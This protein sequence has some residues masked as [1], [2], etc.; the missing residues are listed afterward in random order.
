M[1]TSI[2]VSLIISIIGLCVVFGVLVWQT[3]DDRPT[4]ASQQTPDIGRSFDLVSDDGAPITQE[5]LRGR[6]TLLYFGFTYCPDVCP[7]SLQVMTQA[8]EEIEA[9]E[10]SSPQVTPVFV[11]VDP[12]RDTPEALK[13]YVSHFHPRLQGWTGSEEQI[14]AAM[15]SFKVY[16]ARVDDPTVPDGYTIDHSS[17]FYLMDPNGNFLAHFDHAVTPEKLA[18]TLTQLT[19][20]TKVMR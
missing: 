2:R 17:I 6:F 10:N 12:A 14:A 20:Q 5:F 16:R 8:L 7:T 13:Q 9:F 15:R 11:T 1:K 18:K 4:S 3:G 19:N